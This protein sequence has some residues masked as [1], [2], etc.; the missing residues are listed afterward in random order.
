MLQKVNIDYMWQ[1]QFMNIDILFKNKSSDL[2][3]TIWQLTSYAMITNK[4]Y[5]PYDFNRDL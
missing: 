4:N 2:T 3:A 1:E 5:P